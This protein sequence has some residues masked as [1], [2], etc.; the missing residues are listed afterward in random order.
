MK[1]HVFFFALL[2]ATLAFKEENDMPVLFD[3]NINQFL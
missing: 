1:R 3:K 2:V